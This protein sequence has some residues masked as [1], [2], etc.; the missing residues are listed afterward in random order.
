MT[1][2]NNEIRIEAAIYAEGTPYTT[3]DLVRAWNLYG[4]ESDRLQDFFERFVADQEKPSITDDM[5]RELCTLTTRNEA[6]QHFIQWSNYCNELEA[7]GLIKINR[8]VHAATG[9]A[10]GCDQ[11]SLEVTEDGQAIVDANPELHPA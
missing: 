2:T 1:Y 5:I 9:I 3:D 6:G 8:P 7:L 10:Y 11:W 4:N